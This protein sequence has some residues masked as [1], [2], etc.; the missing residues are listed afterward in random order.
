MSSF[1][2]SNPASAGEIPVVAFFSV[3][4]GFPLIRFAM[5]RRVT[6]TDNCELC[7]TVSKRGRRSAVKRLECVDGVGDVAANV[8]QVPPIIGSTS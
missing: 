3:G 1:A 7:M 5:S 6:A 8:G 4:R 2:L